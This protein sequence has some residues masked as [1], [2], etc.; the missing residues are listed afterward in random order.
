MSSACC[1]VYGS[2]QYDGS[3][4]PEDLYIGNKVKVVAEGPVYYW[5]HSGDTVFS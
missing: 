2:N 3:S 4:A 5:S 1:V